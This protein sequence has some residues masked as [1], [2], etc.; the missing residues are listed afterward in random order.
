MGKDSKM[1]VETHIIIVEAMAEKAISEIAQALSR[2]YPESGM[3][4]V[5]SNITLHDCLADRWP[6]NLVIAQ[7]VGYE[8]SFRLVTRFF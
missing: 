4:R 6:V 5:D 3:S 2:H 7:V 1:R 8:I